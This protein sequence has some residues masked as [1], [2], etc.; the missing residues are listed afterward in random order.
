MDTQGPHLKK[1]YLRYIQQYRMQKTAC[2]ELLA[3]SSPGSADI[4]GAWARHGWEEDHAFLYRYLHIRTYNTWDMPTF[5]SLLH[6]P[7]RQ[8]AA[9]DSRQAAVH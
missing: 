1:E 3:W 6:P 2:P 7:E 9:H 4:G 8:E 5:V